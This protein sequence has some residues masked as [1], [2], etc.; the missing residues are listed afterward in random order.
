MSAHKNFIK[1]IAE[2]PDPAEVITNSYNLS[3]DPVKWTEQT[4]ILRGEKFSFKDRPYL[5]Q[6][7][8]DDA[9]RIRISKGRQTEMTEWL[10]NKLL[11]NAWKHPGT[12]HL[13]MADRESHTSKF[14]NVRIRDWALK[15]SDVIQNAVASVNDHTATVLRFLNGS[16]AFFHSGWSGFEEARSIPADFAYLDEKQS[17]DSSEL[18]VLEETLGHSKYNFMYEVGTGTLEDSEWHQQW[19]EGT[20]YHWD[21]QSKSWIAKNPGAEVHSYVIPQTIVPWIT[22]DDIEKKRLKYTAFRFVTEVLGGWAK[23]VAKPITVKMMRAL[24]DKNIHL[25]VPSQVDRN[26]GPVLLGIDWG[27]G[28]Q[29]FT[30][31]WLVQAIDIEIPI[32]RLIYVKKIEDTDVEKQADKI[33]QVIEAFEPDLGVMDAGGGPRQAQKIENRYATKIPKCVFMTRPEEP[34]KY[35]ELWSRNIIKIDRTYS[36]DSIIDLINRPHIDSVSKISVPRIQIPFAEPGKVEW[37]VDHFT[38]IEAKKTKLRSGQE[39]IIYD[40]DIEN[41]I[42]ALMACNYA[43]IAFHLW[44]RRRQRGAIATGTLGGG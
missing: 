19:M 22:A 39:H 36:I 30:V 12:V 29:A 14:S 4:R 1:A 16:I 20:Q 44:K 40:H 28:E 5:L 35:D 8:R 42:D 24:F 2:A 11:H 15:T 37:I 18:A 26:L 32:F 34:W 9:H 21:T 13:Y 10:A 17:M 41:P 31:P 3:Q 33:I 38:A 25:L 27:G 7:Y 23:G 6:I 43:N